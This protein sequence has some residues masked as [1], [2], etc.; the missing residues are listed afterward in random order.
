[1]SSYKDLT[2]NDIKTTTSFLNQLVDV[3]AEGSYSPNTYNWTWNAKNLASGVYF[4]KTQVG[5]DV[6]AQ[7]V[8]LLK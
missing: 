8:M 4:I 6:S 5:S 7:K 3:V 1:M 2:A